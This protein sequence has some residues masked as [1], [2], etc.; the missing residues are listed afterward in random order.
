MS[1]LHGERLHV[2]IPKKD[3]KDFREGEHVVVEKVDL[4]TPNDKD[5][6][7]LSDLIAGSDKIKKTKVMNAK[8]MKARFD[9][10]SGE[11]VKRPGMR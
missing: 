4:T 5:L 7:S 1:K 9:L 3:R 2:E 11:E 6:F 10:V 8:I